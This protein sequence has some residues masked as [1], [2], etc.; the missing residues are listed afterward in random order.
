MSMHVHAYDA[1]NMYA[2]EIGGIYRDLVQDEEIKYTVAL[3]KFHPVTMWH[4]QEDTEF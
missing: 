2:V 3:G 1:W 4:G